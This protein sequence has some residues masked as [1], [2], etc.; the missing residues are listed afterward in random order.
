[1]DLVLTPGDRTRPNHLHREE[2]KV[3]GVPAE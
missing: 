3:R 2:T 1:M